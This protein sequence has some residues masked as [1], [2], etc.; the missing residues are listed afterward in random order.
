[1]QQCPKC[2]S[3]V[4][5]GR[6]ECQICGAEMDPETTK[7]TGPTGLQNPVNGPRPLTGDEDLGPMPGIPG[8]DRPAEADDVLAKQI[9]GG[10]PAPQGGVELR[11]TLSGEVIEVPVA[12]PQRAGGPML[13]RAGAS[14][15]PPRPIPTAGPAGRSGS[16]VPP[17]RSSAG[18]TRSVGDEGEAGGKSSAGVVLLVLLILV[19]AGAAAGYWYWQQTR[20]AAAVTLFMESVN[21]KKWD[22][23]YDQVELPAQAKQAVSKDLFVKV[24]GMVGSQL[25]IDSYTIKGTKIEGDTAKVTVDSAVSVGAK[26]SSSTGDI[27]LKKVDGVWKIDATSGAPSVPGMSVPNL[28]GLK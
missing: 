25:T 26:K 12:A 23:V 3:T 14:G 2:A 5:D 16:A 1:M 9:G 6:T 13:G 4:P 17:L 21:A 10:Q 11:R 27:S 7:V 28:P 15:T 22:A 18:P 19:L 20:P 24:M 8:I